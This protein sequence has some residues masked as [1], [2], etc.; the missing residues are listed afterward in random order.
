MTDKEDLFN[1]RNGNVCALCEHQLNWLYGAREEE[2]PVALTTRRAV[3]KP[4]FE[5]L[6]EKYESE[7]V[8]CDRR[9]V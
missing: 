4:C 6:L 9:K 3:C 5:V 1:I 8:S 2:T 7:C